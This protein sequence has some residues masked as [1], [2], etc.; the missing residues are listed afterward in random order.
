MVVQTGRLTLTADA[1]SEGTGDDF[2]RFT[3]VPFPTPFPA[4]SNVVVVPMVQTFHGPNT[5]GVRIGQ[6]DES[7]FMIRMN[8]LIGRE[9]NAQKMHSDGFHVAEDVGWIAFTV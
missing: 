9:N 1:P 2:S 5:P 4:D 6:V 7:G 8:E 3:H